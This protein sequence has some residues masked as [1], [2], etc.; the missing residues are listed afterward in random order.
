LNHTTASVT[1]LTG[2]VLAGALVLTGGSSDSTHE[3]MSGMSDSASASSSTGASADAAADFSDADVT[4]AQGMLP[5]HQQAVEMA[6]LA[7]ERAADPRVKDLAAR[8]ENAQEPEIETLTGW[9]EDWGVE[10]AAPAGWT[11]EH[12]PR[13]HGRDDVE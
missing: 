3:G 5:H 9:L 10:P 13:R 6:Q 8:I 12:G 11:T 7:G 1:G 4:F 2:A